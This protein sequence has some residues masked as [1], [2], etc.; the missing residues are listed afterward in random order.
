M[1]LSICFLL[2]AALAPAQSMRG[3]TDSQAAAEAANEH[4][5]QALPQP[6]LIRAYMERMAQQPHHAGS[7]MDASV[8]QYAL[9][10]FKSFG[11]EAHIEDFEALIPYPTIRVVELTAPVKFELKLKEP[12]VAGDPYSSEQGQLPTF[13]AYSASGD[14][15]GELVYVNQGIPADYDYLAKQGIDVKGKIVI[16]RYGGS[17][18]GIK[19][20]VAY[21]HGAIGC[22]I[23]SDPRDDGYFQG[24]TY[25]KGAPS[26]SGG[27]AAR[28]RARYAD[29]CRR[30]SIARLG[31]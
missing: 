26:S 5:A 21:E 19:P 11:L 20:K 6:N 4:K 31:I 28:Q 12:P 13:N 2:I 1:K 9:G 16:A 14:V 7:P 22:I 17:W 15:T 25:P 24:D 30:S 27:R 18:R 23:Y 3:Y 8:A 10:L 29:G